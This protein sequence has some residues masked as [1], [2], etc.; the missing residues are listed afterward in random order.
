MSVA[1]LVV[2]TRHV[3]GTGGVTSTDR[4]RL[5]QGTSPYPSAAN[6]SAHQGAARPGSLRATFA[7]DWQSE[8]G[9]DEFV[10]VHEAISVDRSRDKARCPQGVRVDPMT[11]ADVR[12]HDSHSRYA[13]RSF[14][15]LHFFDKWY[16]QATKSPTELG[17]EDI[18]N[19]QVEYLSKFGWTLAPSGGASGNQTCHDARTGNTFDVG[20]ANPNAVLSDVTP[21]YIIVPDAAALADRISDD[22]FIVALIREPAS[23]ALSHFQME[24]RE[25]YEGTEGG[26]AMLRD[27]VAFA[28]EFEMHVR[29]GIKVSERCLRS[30]PKVSG[31]CRH[32]GMSHVADFVWRGLY[33]VHLDPWIRQFGRNKVLLWVSEEFS[34]DPRAHLTELQRRVWDGP[35][36]ELGEE[37]AERFNVDEHVVFPKPESMEL[38]KQFYREYNAV[39]CTTLRQWGYNRQAAT[40]ERLW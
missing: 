32:R 15:R 10:Q 14:A 27:S 22:P 26:E 11:S 12:S 19:L 39:L 21:R 4:V 33:V 30:F 6:C 23:R 40:I 35:Q 2:D 25:R 8:G 29:Q 17:E 13:H 38:L 36:E 3:I 24:W 28:E 7:G 9:D 37:F 16:Q 31:A 18:R 1:R 20:G 5:D 34:S